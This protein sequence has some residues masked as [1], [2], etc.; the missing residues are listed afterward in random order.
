M[1]HENGSADA[2][3]DTVT[4][5]IPGAAAYLRLARLAAADTGARAGLSVGDLEDLRIAV[6]ELA[7]A[8]IGDEPAGAPMTLRYVAS[9]GMVEIDGVCRANGSSA[10]LSDL[11]GTIVSAIADEH[12][13]HDDGEVC[14]F[15]LVKRTRV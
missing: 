9:E 2:F 14:R 8:L 12:E 6:D 1:I 13:I 4:L 7:Y 10:I 5:T 15:R 3:G 11:A